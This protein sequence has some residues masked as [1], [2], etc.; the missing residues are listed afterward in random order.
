MSRP[1]ADCGAPLRA[2]EIGLTLKMVSRKSERF[3]C[4]KCLAA[5]LGSTPAALEECI[6]AFRKQGCALFTPIEGQS[7]IR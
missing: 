1:C 3:Y 5:R 2:D 6:L 7:W 4:V